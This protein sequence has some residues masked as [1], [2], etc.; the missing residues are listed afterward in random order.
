MGTP[1]LVWRGRAGHVHREFGI[2]SKKDKP[3]FFGTGPLKSEVLRQ[4]EIHYTDEER[5]SSWSYEYFYCNE[6][7]VPDKPEKPKDP[8]SNKP[9][10]PG[11][12]VAAYSS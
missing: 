3:Y 1:W 12:K 6:A 11:K 2:D 4:R 8:Q 9:N 7:D 10:Q 5:S